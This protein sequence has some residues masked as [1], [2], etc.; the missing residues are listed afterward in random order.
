MAR[1]NRPPADASIS[2]TELTAAVTFAHVGTYDPSNPLHSLRMYVG[3]KAAGSSVD[4]TGSVHGVGDQY[5]ELVNTKSVNKVFVEELGENLKGPLNKRG[6]IKLFS[7]K[8]EEAGGLNH[9]G[10]RTTN[11]TLPF[12]GGSGHNIGPSFSNSTAKLPPGHLDSNSTPKSVETAFGKNSSRLESKGT[13]VIDSN[14]NK[15]NK[16]DN[17]ERQVR[18]NLQG[19]IAYNESLL[20][21]SM[22]FPGQKDPFY[23]TDLGLKN[24]G[25]RIKDTTSMGTTKHA[26]EVSYSS[27]GVNLEGKGGVLLSSK[28]GPVYHSFKDDARLHQGVTIPNSSFEPS[29]VVDLTKV[30]GVGNKVNWKDSPVAPMMQQLKQGMKEFTTGFTKVSKLWS[31]PPPPG[32]FGDGLVKATKGGGGVG[33]GIHGVGHGVGLEGGSS[34][35]GGFLGQVGQQFR[36][37]AIWQAYAPILGAAGVAAAYYTGISDPADRAAHRLV[38]VNYNKGQ[39]GQ[40]YRQALE[41]EASRAYTKASD[42]ITASKEVASNLDLGKSPE[43]LKKVGKA[44]I[45]GGHYAI[46]AEQEPKQAIRTLARIATQ[47]KRNV[48]SLHSRP[49][50]D[51]FENTASALGTIQETSSVTGPEMTGFTQRAAA[52]LAKLGWHP[53][54]IIAYGAHMIEGGIPYGE[55]GVFSKKMGVGAVSEKIAYTNL[56]YEETKRRAAAGKGAVSG[57]IPTYKEM[58]KLLNKDKGRALQQEAERVNAAFWSGDPKQAFG[59]LTKYANRFHELSAVGGFPA[60]HLAERQSYNFLQNLYDMPEE[61]KEA[62]YAKLGK[63]RQ[64]WDDVHGYRQKVEEAGE[65]NT[66]GE[67]WGRFAGTV[68]KQLSFMGRNAQSVGRN[69]YPNQLTGFVNS[70]GNASQL[71]YA[72]RNNDTNRIN[73]LK[74]TAEE[75][76]RKG[77]GEK[78]DANAIKANKI[79]DTLLTS[80]GEY[81][82][83]SLPVIGGLVNIA[84]DALWHTIRYANKKLLDDVDSSRGGSLEKF[85]ENARDWWHG[86]SYPKAPSGYMYKTEKNGTLTMLPAYLGG[87]PEG[88]AIKPGAPGYQDMNDP[89]NWAANTEDPAWRQQLKD[90]QSIDVNAMNSPQFNISQPSLDYLIAGIQGGQGGA[91]GQPQRVIVEFKNAPPGTTATTVNPAPTSPNAQPAGQP[92]PQSAPRGNSSYPGDQG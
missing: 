12:S 77:V 22:R 37:A 91:G 83:S 81:L 13:R 60:S 75:E 3:D 8:M 78:I 82:G 50:E 46:Q 33:G 43:D 84:G 21:S 32:S 5:K 66:P 48:P 54:E 49:V 34:K 2:T 64:A 52:S 62:M 65:V 59:V 85:T 25:I 92:P 73:E 19:G 76:Y 4:F 28:V 80:K 18:S 88:T 9:L 26:R 11:V 31:S 67:Q 53:G 57:A 39:R 56:T 45:I 58:N 27:G 36:H 89:Q 44:A 63:G 51:L 17:V 86:N 10:A 7:Q 16:F 74:T 47:F 35:A 41:A 38:G 40:I 87:G 69:T 68:Y 20:R 24:T 6:L 61:N 23:H 79:A 72:M 70:A 1:K 55:L 29:R 71:H 15:F 14:F 90:K 42:V 30:Q